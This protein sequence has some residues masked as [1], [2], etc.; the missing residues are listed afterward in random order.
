MNLKKEKPNFQVQYTPDDSNRAIS[1]NW[2]AKLQNIF[3]PKGK[4]KGN[5]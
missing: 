5:S 3:L 2:V 4:T 1:V